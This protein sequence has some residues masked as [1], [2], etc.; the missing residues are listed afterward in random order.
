MFKKLIFIL[1]VI[2]FITGCLKSSDDSCKLTESTAVAPA[3][4]IATLQLYISANNPAAIQHSSGLFYE[5]IAPGS[6]NAPVA[7]SNVTVRYAGYF[8]NGAK[9]E[10]PPSAVTF[11]LGQLIAGWQR[12]I[13]LIKKGGTIKLYLPP[14]LAYGSAGN[15]TIPPNS[16]LIF[17]I[18]LDN[19]Q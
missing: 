6:G 19:V 13:P 8:T 14:S 12:G 1:P 3:S 17:V 2:F 5:I 4:E 11:L 16:I 18:Q 10:E 9:F 7:C 15:A